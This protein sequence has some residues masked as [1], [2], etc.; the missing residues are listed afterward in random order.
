L[1]GAREIV[2]KHLS[3]L[4]AFDWDSLRQS[5][6]DGAELVLVGGTD[7]GFSSDVGSLYRHITQA[8]D[9]F[10]VEDASLCDDDSGRV[11]AKIRL[12]NGDGG[13][14]NVRGE[15]ATRDGR[16]CCIR[17]AVTAPEP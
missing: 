13:V 10:P 6:S 16:I 9:Y 4:W 3:A 2:A 17:L 12:T 7:T 11:T 14:K 1:A 8:W 5:V 15:Y